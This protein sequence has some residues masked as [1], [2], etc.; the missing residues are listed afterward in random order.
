MYIMLLDLPISKWKEPEKYVIFLSLGKWVKN[1]MNF[2]PTIY[3][4]GCTTLFTGKSPLVPYTFFLRLRL[5]SSLGPERLDIVDRLHKKLLYDSVCPALT[6][7]PYQSL[8]NASLNDVFMYWRLVF[9]FY[10]RLS[11]YFSV[12]LSLGLLTC[13]FSYF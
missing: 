6:H 10:F 11:F 7:S 5:L 4:N 9:W 12:C 1:I 3:P 13:L 8:I 2:S